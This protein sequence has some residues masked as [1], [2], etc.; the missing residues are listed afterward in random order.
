MPD[1][2]LT[3]ELYHAWL[4]V[5]AIQG[6]ES[7]LIAAKVPLLGSHLFPPCPRK[8]PPP[9]TP[10]PGGLPLTW[11]SC[12]LTG[13]A[14]AAGPTAAS[15]LRHP[16]LPMPLP[17]PPDP[18]FRGGE[19]RAAKRCSTPVCLTRLSLVQDNKME[20]KNMGIVFGPNLMWPP[21]VVS[22]QINAALPRVGEN[23]VRSLLA[24][25]AGWASPT[26]AFV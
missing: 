24:P 11:H 8:A 26:R 1:C 22:V 2:L 18:L 10:P 3:G 23:D 19:G 12:S 15:Q 17:P 5:P 4:N 21:Y 9:P 6:L 13:H 14:G 25:N 16:T 7:Q 20:P